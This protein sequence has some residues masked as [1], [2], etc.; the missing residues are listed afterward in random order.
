LNQLTKVLDQEIIKLVAQDPLVIPP[1]ENL[2]AEVDLLPV[3]R[4]VDT[5]K[6][7]GENLKKLKLKKLK[8]S[9]NLEMLKKRKKKKKLKIRKKKKLKLKKKITP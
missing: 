6:E 1:R 7:T 2:T 8:L 3:K 9:L 4:K 5:E